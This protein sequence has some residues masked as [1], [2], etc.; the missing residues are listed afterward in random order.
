MKPGD[1]SRWSVASRSTVSFLRRLSATL[2][3]Y[4]GILAVMSLVYILGYL[5]V[6][7]KLPRWK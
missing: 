5:A 6:Y 1:D 2:L 4:I 3:Q 7:Q